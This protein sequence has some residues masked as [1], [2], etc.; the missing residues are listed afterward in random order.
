MNNIAI[1]PAR[2]GSKGLKNKNI[3][4]L[5]G[6]QALTNRLDESTEEYKKLSLQ[7]TVRSER[8]MTQNET[9]TAFGYM[10]I[11]VYFGYSLNNHTMTIPD[12]LILFNYYSIIGTPLVGLVQGFMDFKKS[13]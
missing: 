10:M 13:F 12:A 1:I 4:L 8:H 5:N 3:K 6:K 11:M 7:A 9:F 2:S